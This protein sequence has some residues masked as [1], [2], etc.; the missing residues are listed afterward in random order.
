MQEEKQK[1][2][3]KKKKHSPQILSAFVSQEH[4]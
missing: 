4:S 2:K 1:K 3:K